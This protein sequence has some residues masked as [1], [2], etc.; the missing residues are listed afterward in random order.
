MKAA[1]I[2]LDIWQWQ[3][4]VLLG[5]TRADFVA[6]VK[7]ALGADVESQEGAQG[8][9]Y[10]ERGK[11]WVLWVANPKDEATLAHEALHITAG[12]LE[13]RGLKLSG[14]SEEA[15]TYT[16]ARIITLARSARYRTVRRTSR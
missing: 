1:D 9:A 7:A 5:G 13:S 4:V 2:T 15:Y 12:V 8:H 11:P 3:G 14:D 10:M 6:W 16:L